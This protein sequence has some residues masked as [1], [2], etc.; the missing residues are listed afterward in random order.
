MGR[1]GASV[2]ISVLHSAVAEELLLHDARAD[3]AEGE[4]MDL[5][6]GMAFLP[7]AAVRAV[8]LDE[9]HETDA[10]VI[11]AGKSGT[12]SQ[13]RLELARE[14]AGI[15]RSI[16]ASLRGYSGLVVVVTNPVDV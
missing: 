2:A 13:S 1:V 8:S 6:H 7:R 12:A 11:A 4:A 15:V 16:A 10:V 3:V 5:V 14:N 9:I